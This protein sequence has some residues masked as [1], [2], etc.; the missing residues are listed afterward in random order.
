MHNKR[1]KVMAWAPLWTFN[2]PL[3]MRR[4]G[5]A[6]W[7]GRRNLSFQYSVGDAYILLKAPSQGRLPFNTPL[8]MRLYQFY[9][10]PGLSGHHF[11][12]SVGD[13][14]FGV[15]Y[16]WVDIALYTFNTPLEML[17]LVAVEGGGAVDTFNTPLEM[18]CTGLTERGS[19]S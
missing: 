18:H 13:A 10:Y 15:N 3:E 11:Q 1:L 6:A 8:E 2:T 7:G 12:Y 14:I 5:G 4:R 19:R 16:I 17:H 9:H